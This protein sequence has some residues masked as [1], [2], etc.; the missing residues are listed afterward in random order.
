MNNT[1]GYT[2]YDDYLRAVLGA[3]ADKFCEKIDHTE[4]VIN[5]DAAICSFYDGTS[6][7]T[8]RGFCVGPQD[9]FFTS[10]LN[11]VNVD[12]VEDKMIHLALVYSYSNKLLSIYINGILT[13]VVRNTID[14]TGGSFTIRQNAI[15][16][17]SN[18]C[19]FNLYKMRIYNTNL[20]INYIDLNLAAD[21]KDI[22][23][24]DQTNL[25]K[26][27]SNLNEYQFD[28]E[29]MLEYN[30]THPDNELMPYVVWTTTG[31]DEKTNLL[32]YSKA[33]VIKANMEFHNVALDRAYMT[34]KLS[35]YAAKDGLTDEACQ[36]QYGM[37]AVEYYY[38]HH[39][40]SWH[41][42]NVEMKVQGTS[43]EFYPRRNYK[44]KTKVADASG[45][46]KYVHMYMNGGPF[47][48]KEK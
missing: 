24:Y 11:T 5:T 10:G 18:S 36:E 3:D 17:N 20:P 35:D 30:K 7:H 13:G 15:K 39:C 43:S 2:N 33:N 45:E 29:A 41:G 4:K 25:A 21:Q 22:D 12:Y 47:T 37:S 28:Y 23:I 1:G 46:K 48:G 16:F 8:G 42:E 9:A 26:W 14:G 44:V 32:P 40:P 19:D 27:N 6:S 34:G 31:S 38:L